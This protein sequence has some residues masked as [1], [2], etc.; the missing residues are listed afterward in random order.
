[1]KDN[2]IISSY[3]DKQEIISGVAGFYAPNKRELSESL[4][5]IFSRVTGVTQHLDEIHRHQ[6]SLG[7]KNPQS[8]V[9]AITREY[10]ANYRSAITLSKQ[11]GGLALWVADVPNPKISLLD[12]ISSI[13]SEHRA[14]V[15]FVDLRSVYSKTSQS[16][17]AISHVLDY[18]YFSKNLETE[19]YLTSRL[20]EITINMARKS[21]VDSLNDQQNRA[22]FWLDTLSRIKNH[23]VAGPIIGNAVNLKT[24]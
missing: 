5:V 8:A 9:M 1:M 12:E 16:N 24:K 23:R 11:L 7:A 20:G 19:K 18:S 21:V 4:T 3:S 6:Q 10:I 17:D 15:R 13:S 14:F 22:I 2:T